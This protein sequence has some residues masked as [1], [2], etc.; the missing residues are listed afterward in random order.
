MKKTE[1]EELNIDFSA[2]KDKE[3][4]LDAAQR[5]LE[6]GISII[7][8]R[9]SK[10]PPLKHWKPYQEKPASPEQLAKWF[11]RHQCIAIIC[12]KVSGNI[13]LIDFDYDKNRPEIFNEWRKLVEDEDPELFKKLIIQT[14][15][16]N[17]FHVC[18]SCREIQIPG[19]QTLAQYSNGESLKTLIET[20][21]EGGYFLADPSP[22]YKLRQG[23]FIDIPQITPS[24]REILLRC[25]KLLNEHTPPVRSPKASSND[26]SRSGLS[27]GDDFNQRGDIR[28]FLEGK[29]WTYTGSQGDTER[30]RRPGKD[31]GSSASLLDSKT[32]YNFSSNAHPLEQGQSYDLFGLYTAYEH[33]GDFKAAARALAQQ[34][35]GDQPIKGQKKKRILTFDTLKNKFQEGT[36]RWIWRQHIPAGM[37]II[38]NGREGIGK[39]TNCIQMAKEILDTYRQNSVVWVASE[40]FIKDT[41]NKFEH[42]GVDGSRLFIL[43]NEDENNFTFNFASRKDLKIL[44]SYL[45]QA[46]G[47]NLPTIAVFIDSIRGISPYDDNESKIKTPMMALNSIVCDQHAAALVYLDHWSKGQKDNLLDKAVG[48]TAKTAAVRAVYSI[49]SESAYTR[50]IQCAKMNLL[51]QEPATLTSVESSRG[52]IIYEATGKTDHSLVAQA[53]KYLIEMFSLK[54]KYSA[55]D[56]YEE[57]EER[58]IGSETLKKAKRKLG[59]ES[60]RGEGIGG[61]WEW[62]CTTFIS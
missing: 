40:G 54:P 36:V 55:Q 28:A 5:F 59:I 7:P 15:Q 29:G 47:E 1:S 58:G 32:F 38:V 62:K 2:P 23:N 41:I 34:G 14:T 13:E 4:L 12:G 20:R 31:R 27:P 52:I 16:N 19:N 30:W 45:T 56:I 43:E 21:G 24:E 22:G 42:L 10:Q 9:K 44:D 37:P 39:T 61:S 48:T 57:A 33:G 26:Q 8:A 11:P 18:Y 46:A 3:T 60:V 53:E 25:A 51:G 17:G 49:T 35:Y 6:A 50:L